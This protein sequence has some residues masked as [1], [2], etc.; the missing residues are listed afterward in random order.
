MNTLPKP[1]LFDLQEWKLGTNKFMD[2]NRNYGFVYDK[3]GN[4]LFCHR[5]WLREARIETTEFEFRIGLFETDWVP[6]LDQKVFY[7]EELT[8]KGPEAHEVV[9]ALTV[10]MMRPQ[11]RSLH[12]TALS[13]W[14]TLSTY[15]VHLIRDILT[16][17]ANN[18]IKG[19]DW[20]KTAEKKVVVFEGNN[21]PALRSVLSQPGVQSL[22]GQPNTRL[23]F[24]V[25]VEGSWVGCPDPR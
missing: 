4:E 18:A 13:L 7:R 19:F 20:V 24:Q 17:T 3:D 15:R 6:N 8:L 1:Q 14:E 10:Q 23:E 11:I 9:D 22:L 2:V 12:A 16:P 25:K 5:D 21:V